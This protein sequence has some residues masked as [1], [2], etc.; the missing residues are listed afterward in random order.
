[1]SKLDN[2]QIEVAEVV[3]PCENLAENLAFFTATLGFRIESIYPADTPRIAVVSAYGTRLRLEEKSG[4]SPKELHLTFRGTEIV[5]GA[6]DELVAP[7]GTRVKFEATD[8]PPVIPDLVPSLT[9]QKVGGQPNWVIGRA[10]MQYRDLIPDRLGG[11]YIASHIRIPEGGPVPDYVHHH[12][13]L[14]QLIYCYKGWVRVVYEDQ[15]L[16][17]LM[18]PGDCVFSHHISGTRCWNAP[19]GSR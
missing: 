19:K 1:M 11:R 8:I 9:V 3:F 6:Y 18:H 4:I 17:F 14:F 7:N 13:I 15:G 5:A 12:H 16:P 2:R 10:G